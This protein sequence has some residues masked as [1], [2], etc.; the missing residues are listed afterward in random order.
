[1][2]CAGALASDLHFQERLAMKRLL[3]VFAGLVPLS[4]VLAG[5]STG[6][7]GSAAEKKSREESARKMM[8]ESQKAMQEKMGQMKK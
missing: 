8:E 6:S 7:G 1:M 5:C 2:A 4:L 3:V